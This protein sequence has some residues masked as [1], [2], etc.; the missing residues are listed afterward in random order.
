M[1]I[2]IAKII[3]IVGS[4]ILFIFL[5]GCCGGNAWLKRDT[6]DFQRGLWKDC[7]R[8]MCSKIENAV[9]WVEAVRAF[10]VL[11]LVATGGFIALALVVFTVHRKKDLLEFGWSYVFGWIGMTVAAVIAVIGVLAAR[12]GCCLRQ[13]QVKW[14][15]LMHFAKALE[16]LWLVFLRFLPSGH[17]Q[18]FSK[19]N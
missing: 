12:A 17:A 2:P 9:D 6:V 7:V 3:L 4:A 8:D 13:P 14:L 18:C 16:I 19:Q 5:A 10:A 1:A 15:L 11:A